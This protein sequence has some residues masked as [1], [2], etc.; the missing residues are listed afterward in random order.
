MY[1]T[2]TLLNELSINLDKVIIDGT[3]KDLS[4]TSLCIYSV[5]NELHL[6]KSIQNISS[7]IFN[8]N[9]GTINKVYCAPDVPPTMSENEDR[10]GILST[11]TENTI[12]Y[13]PRNS[14]NQYKTDEYWSKCADNIV[15]Y[16]F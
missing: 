11:F 15:G 7:F 14:V 1:T 4:N 6:C 12:I 16:D 5:L 10:R 3:I 8:I 13:V 9:S 2:P